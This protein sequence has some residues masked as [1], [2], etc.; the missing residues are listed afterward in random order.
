M[1]GLPRPSG[2]QQM[3]P[4]Y[5]KKRLNMRLTFMTMRAIC[6]CAIAILT[7]PALTSAQTTQP[8]AQAAKVPDDERKAL[9]KINT[10]TGPAA[11]M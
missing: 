11:K 3:T 8:P 7:A 4:H 5:E 1:R 10:V 2:N 9:E 6:L